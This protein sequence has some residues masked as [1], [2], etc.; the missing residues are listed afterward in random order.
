M[1]NPL[2]AQGTLNRL[3]GS[4]TITDLPELNVTAPFLGK[5]G[6]LMSFEG[7]STVYI[8]TMTGAVTSPEP[9][10]RA[11]VVVNLLKTQQI[12]NLY[13]LQMEADSNIGDMIIR[14]DAASLS[15]YQF[16]NCSI[17]SVQE[18][19]F[20]G[21]TAGYAVSLGGIY[22]INSSLFNAA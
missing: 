10:L 1:A 8:D 6:I 17:M 14:T 9:Y 5:E 13:K 3:R 16:T 11:T 7:N 21:Q 20:N 12:S 19:S 4:V 22:Y 15:D 18:L 2:I